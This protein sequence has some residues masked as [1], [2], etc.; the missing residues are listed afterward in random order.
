VTVPFEENLVGTKAKMK[1]TECF[2]WHVEGD[3]LERNVAS[4]SVPLN[5]F[6]EAKE[7]TLNKKNQPKKQ[8]K[9]KDNQ[10]ERLNELV[11]L[12]TES[13]TEKEEPESE[14]AVSEETQEE[15]QQDVAQS[16]FCDQLQIYQSF[17]K[18]CNEL[19]RLQVAALAIL[20]LGIVL[21][22]FGL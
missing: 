5:Y 9:L 15:V 1:I 16:E 6:D 10:I 11:D 14:E 8:K 7:I 2:K 21:K 4:E 22:I 3:I 17:L 19:S 18:K 20:F 12:N 13:D